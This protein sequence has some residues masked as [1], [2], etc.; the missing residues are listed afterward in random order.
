[1]LQRVTKFSK[2]VEVQAPAFASLTAADVIRAPVIQRTIPLDFISLVAPF[3]KRR[4]RLSLRVEFVP[5]RAR[6][7][8]GRNNGDG[9]WSLASDELEGLTYLLPDNLA[10]HTL[11]L[12]IMTLEE[13][14]A[15][16]LKIHHVPV[17][18]EPLSSEPAEE[19]QA[20]ARGV[21]A[22]NP[23]LHNQLDKMHSLFAVRE[24]E[25]TELRAALEQAKA[26]KDTEL[27][28]ARAGWEQQLQQ[29]LT[30]AITQAKAEWQS[31]QKSRKS[32][33]DKGIAQAE[34]QAEQKIAQEGVLWQAQTEERLAAERARLKSESAGEL[35]EAIAQERKRWLAESDQRIETERAR[36]KAESAGEL[37]GTVGQERARWHAEADQRIETER[38]RW[39][40]E[41]AGELSG[42]VA[43]ERARWQ[44]ETDQRIETERLR[45]KTESAGELSRA[46][47]QERA[48]WQAEADQRIE[49]E[50]L[51]WKA[52]S[53][54]DLSV[55]V[56]QES[57][58]W[59][60]ET[61]K[62]LEAERRRW[63]TESQGDRSQ[64][65]AQEH[66]RW[67]LEAEQRLE[68]ERERWKAKSAVVLS[69]ATRKCKALEIALAEAQARPD[70]HS[71]ANEDDSGASRD[72]LARMQSLL[73]RRDLELDQHRTALEQEREQRRQ[74]LEASLL[75]AAK[76]WKTEEDLRLAAM[77]DKALAQSDAALAAVNARCE[78]AERA[79]ADAK[80]QDGS[81]RKD[82]AYVQGL[83]KEVATLRAGLVN[84]EVELGHAK[85]ALDRARARVVQSDVPM[86]APR[87]MRSIDDPI[88]EEPVVS[89]KRG[90]MR[91]FVVAVCVITPLI[92]FY[93][94]LEMYLPDDVRSNIATVTGGILGG[95]AYTAPPIRAAAPPA[96][97]TV[98]RKMAVVNHAANLR[99]TPGVKGAVILT[100]PRGA[101]V[102]IIEE[103]GNWTLV[104]IVAKNE[105]EKPQQGFAFSS[106]L[107]SNP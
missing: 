55:A 79:L 89:S 34:A 24:S 33:G 30:E 102:R 104:E 103:R 35:L 1:M 96:K 61:E 45:W 67:Q 18:L 72:E 11:L 52:E 44:A 22:D 10:E 53:A 59:Q 66:A 28:K 73:I 98:E 93:P 9:S 90:L 25:L 42:V 29:R 58:R 101:A 27:A 46:I 47:A 6:L 26:E 64:A 71:A 105:K 43:Q 76:T 99:A 54:G 37:S 106:Y 94:R 31:E 63:K 100:L 12:R 13:A 38:L 8:A 74:E 78:A 5:Q 95:I 68:T 97:P 16:T 2:K 3:K 56:A 70:I 69:E 81:S 107:K 32:A 91:D 19:E 17:S 40:T 23:I 80:N 85:V 57:A 49:T 51:R 83:Q 36:W 50:R 84:R 21:D 7:S 88:E 62:R 87:R 77:M 86:P 20:T 15:T 4:G 92:F 41:S 82:D 60:V 48:R 39:K 14:G 75:A 65:L